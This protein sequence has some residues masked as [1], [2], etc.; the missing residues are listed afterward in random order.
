MTEQ[1]FSRVQ[2]T[3][4]AQVSVE[5][6]ADEPVPDTGQVS[7]QVR[8]Q[9]PKKAPTMVLASVQ[10]PVQVPVQVTVTVSLNA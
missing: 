3:E 4:Q 2:V 7:T 1:V 9:G 10:V 8:V 6:H 5:V